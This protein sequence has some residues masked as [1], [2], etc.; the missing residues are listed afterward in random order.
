MN[1]NWCWYDMLY[2]ES[3]NNILFELNTYTQ[4]ISVYLKSKINHHNAKT[5]SISNLYTLLIS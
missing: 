2:Q 5:Y 4:K 1:L 3:N